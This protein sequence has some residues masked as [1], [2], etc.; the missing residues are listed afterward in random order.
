MIESMRV[1]ASTFELPAPFWDDFVARSWSRQPCLIREPFAEPLIDETELFAILADATSE[2]RAYRRLVSLGVFIDGACILADVDRLLP[3]PT[4]RSLDEYR[5][6][7]EP[8]VGERPFMITVAGLQYFAFD[9]WMRARWFL[10]P[11]FERVGFPANNA[12]LDMFFGRYDQSPGGVHKD[13]AA[14]FS[15]VL[16]ERKTML[17]WPDSYFAARVPQWATS[18]RTMD[19]RP[20]VDDAIVID[21]GRG[22]VIFWPRDFWHVGVSDGGWPT[23]LTVAIFQ[24]KSPHDVLVEALGSTSSLTTPSDMF[25]GRQTAEHLGELPPILRE[26]ARVFQQAASGDGLLQAARRRWL[27]RAS[28][29][30][31]GNVPPPLNAAPIHDRDRVSAEDVGP[32]LVTQSEHGRLSIGANGHIVDVADTPHL[33]NCV[34]LVRSG[35]VGTVGEIVSA[36]TR[37]AAGQDAVECASETK[38]LIEE[39]CRI[40]ALRV[41]STS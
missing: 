28:A 37:N 24:K 18:I 7:L 38:H 27:Q 14:N 9:L 2:F 6:Q 29:S 11:L 26:G 39:L 34:D 10:R 16:S 23:T 1:P 31:F 22:D 21:A 17:F 35:V 36:C 3:Q 40:R 25:G 32:L 13:A 15:Y 5:A 19:Y 4:V 33:R 41:A 20:F 12:D 30:G 8:L